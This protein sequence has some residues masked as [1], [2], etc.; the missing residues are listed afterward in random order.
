V[1]NVRAAGVCEIE[2]GSA[3]GRFRAVEVPLGQTAEV[4]ARYREVAGRTVKPYWEQLPEDKDHP[5]F[6]IEPA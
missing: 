4:I 1:R 5:V 6:R 3:A 2:G